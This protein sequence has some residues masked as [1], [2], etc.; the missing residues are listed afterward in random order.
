MREITAASALLLASILCAAVSVDRGLPA[1]LESLAFAV[2]AACEW[3]TRHSE[4]LLFALA[5]ALRARRAR[6]D[7]I[8]R[9]RREG[10]AR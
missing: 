10:L 1:T 7:A 9:K 5:D 4:L 3:L 2:R 6:V 8:N